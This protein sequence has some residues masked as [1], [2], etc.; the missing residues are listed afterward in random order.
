MRHFKIPW[1]AV[2][3]LLAFASLL[4]FTAPDRIRTIEGNRQIFDVPPLANLDSRLINI[5]TLGHKHIYDDF[6][7]IWLLQTLT[8]TDKPNEPDK[9]L[10]AIRSVIQH[11]PAHESLYMLSC[12]VM[13]Q[14][15]KRPESCQEI[16]MAGLDVFPESWRLPIQQGYVHAYLTDKPAQAASFFMMAASRKNAPEWLKQVVQRLLQRDH[17][18]PEDLRE[19]LN[20]IQVYSER[21]GSTN[22]LQQF[23]NLMPKP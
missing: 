23:Q 13:V 19:S 20:T 1:L 16:I 18:N 10:N 3:C 12:Y 9:M 5:L 15:F 17:L 14:D 11:R 8:E 4:T 7:N 2:S 6:I 21:S 22:L